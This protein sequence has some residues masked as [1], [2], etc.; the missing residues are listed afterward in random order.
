MR[1]DLQ[2][3]TFPSPALTVLLLLLVLIQG[4]AGRPWDSTDSHQAE[5]QFEQLVHDIQQR[6]QKCSQGLTAQAIFHWQAPATSIK[7]NGSLHLLA[8]DF[9]KAVALSPLNQPL[10]ILTSNSTQFQAI[11]IPAAQTME[12]ALKA[13]VRQYGIAI[14]QVELGN[15]LSG[16]LGSQI[17][18][19]QP[20]G[21][22]REKRGYWL[23][24]KEIIR[25]EKIVSRMLIDP[26][27]QEI[28]A[29]VILNS[30]RQAMATISYGD[31]DQEQAC[32]PPKTIKISDLPYGAGLSIRLSRVTPGPSKLSSKEFTIQI[33]DS[34]TR[35]ILP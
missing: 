1:S 11:D 24:I 26:A 17:E 34:F 20:L 35:Q 32:Q 16:R 8:P 29:R 25:K 10:F 19:V 2:T 7:L 6:E 27:T 31:R 12:G 33:P 9:V 4:C 5:V 13:L 18:T 23:V 14:E 28:L 30:E 22:D 21:W 3:G 15:W